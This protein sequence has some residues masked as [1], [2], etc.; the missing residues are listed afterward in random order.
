M[1]NDFNQNVEKYIDDILRECVKKKNFSDAWNRI[2]NDNYGV[3]YNE[4]YTRKHFAKERGTTIYDFFRERE[5]SILLELIMLDS[6]EKV[7]R[8]KQKIYGINKL[9]VKLEDFYGKDF[10]MIKIDKK[11]EIK[12]KVEMIE[13]LKNS[14]IFESFKYDYDTEELTVEF[15]EDVLAAYMLFNFRPIVIHCELNQVIKS[16]GNTQE[17]KLMLLGLEKAVATGSRSIQFFE[18]EIEIGLMRLESYNLESPAECNNTVWYLHKYTAAE[19]DILKK[20]P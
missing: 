1:E 12:R 11:N 3:D 18:E 17:K 14:P 19:K 10:D 2:K 5:Y 13:S 6:Q 7:I 16:A 15:D 20:G 4:D 9:I 8:K